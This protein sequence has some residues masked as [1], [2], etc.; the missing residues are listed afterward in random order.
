MSSRPCAASEPADWLGAILG[1][2]LPQEG[3]TLDIG[4]GHYVM[5]GGILRQEE[6]ASAAQAQTA[7]TFGYKW[8][9]RETYDSDIMQAE[10]GAWLRERYGDP[11]V[12][13]WLSGVSPAPVVLDAGC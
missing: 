12:M 6:L 5:R 3:G 8:Q 2:A 1:H 4:G 7:S 13:P 9:R 10:R 11:D